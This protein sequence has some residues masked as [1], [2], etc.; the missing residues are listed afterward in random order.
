MVRDVDKDPGRYTNTRTVGVE[1]LRLSKDSVYLWDL[2]RTATTCN[3]PCKVQVSSTGMSQ[4][5]GRGRNVAGH[6][7]G[8]NTPSGIMLREISVVAGRRREGLR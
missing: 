4:P 3:A 7:D 8:T 5:L 6:D 2:R 1:T